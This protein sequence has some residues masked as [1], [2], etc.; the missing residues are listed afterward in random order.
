M[1][2]VDTSALVAALTPKAQEHHQVLAALLQAQSPLLISPFVLAELDYLVQRRLGKEA[3]LKLLEEVRRGAYRLELFSAGDLEDAQNVVR[4]YKDLEISLADASIVV[5]ANRNRT[6][7]VLTLD[8]KHFRVL[9]TANG[10]PFELL[11]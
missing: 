4:K 10:E 6:K 9:Q 1:I 2:L 5:L 8:Q 3:Q 11:P 7:S